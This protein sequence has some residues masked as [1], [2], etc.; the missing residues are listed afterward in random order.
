MILV[1]VQVV[2]VCADGSEKC[3]GTQKQARCVAKPPMYFPDYSRPYEIRTKAGLGKAGL[4]VA[5]ANGWMLTG[6]KD[7][8]D[9]SALLGFIAKIG[10]FGLDQSGGSC[11]GAGI[12]K[13]DRVS[14]RLVEFKLFD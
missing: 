13:W 4:D 7:S 12:Y 5:V 3:E 1:E 14:N 10:G 8:T 6:Q 9:N 11:K 2:M